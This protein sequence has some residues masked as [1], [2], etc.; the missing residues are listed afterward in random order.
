VLN[1]KSFLVLATVVAT[2]LT[3]ECSLARAQAPRPAVAPTVA[4]IDINRIFKEHVRFKG[5]TEQMKVDVEAAEAQVKGENEELQRL[6]GS[7][8]DY[9][10]GT[11]EYKALDTDLTTR[12]A[13]LT[14]RIRTQRTEFQQREAQM[15]YT[16]YREIVDEVKRFA[17]HN[18]INLVLRFNAEAPDASVPQEVL[19]ELNKDVVYY[20]AQ[21]DVTQYVLDSLNRRGGVASPAPVNPGPARAPTQGVPRR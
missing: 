14:A 10:A 16:V 3:W 8:K 6:A 9:K 7:I 21:I 11:P 4:I 18:G 15:M 19:R 20:N 17:E 2:L 1:V 12:N 13:Q 5:M